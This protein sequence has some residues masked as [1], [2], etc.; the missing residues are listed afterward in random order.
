MDDISVLYELIPAMTVLTVRDE[1]CLKVYE[2]NG[3]CHI[4]DIMIKYPD[5]EVCFFNLHFLLVLIN[6]ILTKGF[7]FKYCFHNVLVISIMYT[8][9]CCH[10]HKRHQNVNYLVDTGCQV[11]NLKLKH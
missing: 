4:L 3:L 10:S 9:K 2:Q 7:F 5:D 8:S 1:F 6:C 11:N